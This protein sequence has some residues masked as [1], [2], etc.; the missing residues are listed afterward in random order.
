[1]ENTANTIWASAYTPGGLQVGITIGFADGNLPHA[2]DIDR[3]I[4]ERGYLV[5]LPGVEPGEDVEPI[6]YVCRKNHTDTKTGVIVP[7][8]GFYS[9]NDYLTKRWTHTYLDTP[10]QIAEFEN[11]TGLKV[12]K[13]PVYDGDLHPD[14]TKSKAVVRLAKAIKVVRDYYETKDGEPRRPFKR[15]VD[16]IGTL[17]A[18]P[19][20]SPQSS[21]KQAGGKVIEV[22]FGDGQLFADGSKEI[23]TKFMADGKTPYCVVSGITFT[24]LASLK[25]LGV[26]AATLKT[27][28][29]QGTH[30][31]PFM[32]I[33][34]YKVRPDNFKELLYV[35]RT[36][37]GVICD[38]SGA[39]VEL[40]FAS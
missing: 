3:M 13:M 11:G 37:T 17:P 22:D 24:T 34:I 35:K 15:F 30:E 20:S 18:T 40:K 26:P 39:I 14:R 4:A 8:I 10:E 2:G 16:S 21:D 31:L 29:E 19:T 33:P 9:E 1:M 36:D 32:V 23:E 5:T 25:T 7:H 27:F 6:L 38:A 28:I 12:D